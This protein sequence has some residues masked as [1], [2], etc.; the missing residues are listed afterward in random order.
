MLGSSLCDYSDAYIFA[1]ATRT[2]PNTA[3]AGANQNNIKNIIIKNCDPFTNCISEI[4]NTQKDNAENI[5]IIMPMYKLIEYGDNY[6]ETSGSLWQFYRDKPFIIDNDAIAD[7]PAD[8]N[9]SGS[10]KYKTKIAAE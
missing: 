3:A 4:N 6:S 8:N 10:F 1:S 9:N 5:D 2:V 7:F